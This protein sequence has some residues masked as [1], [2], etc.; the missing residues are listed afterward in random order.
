MYYRITFKH[1]NK[2]PEKVRTEIYAK[3]A[4]QEV[5]KVMRREI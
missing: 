1:S 2:A 5:K 3:G 4:W